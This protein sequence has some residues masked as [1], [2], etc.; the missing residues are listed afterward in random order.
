MTKRRITDN[1]PSLIKFE[2]EVERSLR[3]AL[4]IWM[5]KPGTGG[6]QAHAQNLAKHLIARGHQVMVLTRVYTCVPEGLG[7]LTYVEDEPQ[8]EVEGIPVRAVC[9]SRGMRRCARLVAK[10]RGFPVLWR[11]AVWLFRREA[12]SMHE[13]FAGFDLIHYVGQA[14]Q[15]FGFAAADAA[16]H[17]GVP[18]VVQP[19]CHPF[20]VGDSPMDL[21][22]YRRAARALVHT[23]YE[24]DHLGPKLSGLPMDVVGN[25]IEDRNDGD[26][27]AFRTRHGILGPMV[28]YIGRREPD[29]GYPLVVEA[30]RLLHK[31]RP[32][33]TLVC[34][35]PAGGIPK[36]E[37]PG[38]VHFDFADEATKHD[39]LA[40]CTCLCVPS[41]GESFGLVYME[42]GRYAKPVIARRLPVLEE[43]LKD[44]TAGLLVGKM[45]YGSNANQLTAAEL[46]GALEG[47]L[48][49]SELTRTLGK[50]CQ[51]VSEHFIWPRIVERF[52]HA[53]FSALGKV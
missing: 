53:Y 46:A 2:G 41:E 33:A 52:E 20:V 30:Y 40:A 9:Y 43:L 49:D 12:R 51:M 6:L 17:Y 18:F 48:D 7:F 26:G 37:M 11:L 15:M 23:D 39:A 50:K 21:A 29:K 16:D 25:G 36:A 22:L 10:L 3:I 5:F 31:T 45:K 1:L 47:L 28:L 27:A 24:A 14:D 4:C 44:G 38:I 35:G 32:E 13:D 34:M 8:G 42:A 19:T